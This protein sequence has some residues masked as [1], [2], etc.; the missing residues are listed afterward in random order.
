MSSRR[1]FGRTAGAC[2]ACVACVAVA[3]C[4]S[5]DDDSSG[6][7]DATAASSAADGGLIA[8]VPPISDSPYFT[9]IGCG[10]KDAVEAGGYEYLLQ[11]SPKFDATQQTQ[12][13]QGLA[14]RKPKAIAVS[15]TDT[16][17]L[18]PILANMAKTIPIV[19]TVDPIDV[20][21]QSA[22]VRT[23]QIEF[24]R[25]QARELIRVMGESG[26]V[27]LMDYQA[28]SQTLD[29]RATGIKEELAEHPGIEIVS[30]EY[31]VGDPTKAAQITSA[32]LA[33]NP[34][35]KGA[36]STDVYDMEGVVTTIK[37]KDLRDQV[38][39]IAPDNVP[40]TVKWVRNGDIDALV[41]TK[42]YA[43]GQATGEAAVDAAQG[44]KADEIPF[45]LPDASVV[46][47]KDNADLLDTDELKDR[48]C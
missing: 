35:L 12:I 8:F 30:H 11:A 33:R 44:T 42:N 4:G 28:G 47:T 5:S 10:I 36:V 45:L 27:L 46:I 18:T 43:V 25:L 13:L 24:G 26:E 20:A 23:D 38:A 9:T 17:Q 32:V 29:D 19:T 40:N 2:L 3:A 34:D 1:S 39:L 7:A 31:G 48:S 21:G 6:G 15:V 37:Q 16:K 41:A 22:N 14:Q